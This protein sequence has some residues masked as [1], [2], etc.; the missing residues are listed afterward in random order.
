MFPICLRISRGKQINPFA[1]LWCYSSSLAHLNS[2][3]KTVL[4]S[5]GALES[6]SSAPK[7]AGLL[8]LSV[9]AISPE[10][11][12]GL[13]CPEQPHRA[14][15]LTTAAHGRGAPFQ[16]S[17]GP[18][19]AAVPLPVLRPHGSSPAGWCPTL[20]LDLPQDHGAVPDP[21]YLAEAQP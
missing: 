1:L 14:S 19:A 3:T 7:A 12:V 10:A 21:G 18:S 11:L 15:H 17:Q 8:R 6:R 20:S 5:A 13:N 16:L 9:F 2:S 4:L